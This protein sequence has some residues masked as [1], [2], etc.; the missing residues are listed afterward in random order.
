MFLIHLKTLILYCSCPP[1][2]WQTA[3]NNNQNNNNKSQNTQ[4][5]QSEREI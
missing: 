1:A 4:L 2:K 3:N 5:K